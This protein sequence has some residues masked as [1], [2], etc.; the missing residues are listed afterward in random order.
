MAWLTAIERR[1]PYRRSPMD[2]EELIARAEDLKSE[3]EKL[4]REFRADEPDW[5][6][7]ERILPLDWCG[8]F[9]FMGYSGEI[10][11]YK[12]GLTRRYLNVDPEGNTCAY[13]GETIGY[14]KIPRERAIEAAFAGLEE[15]GYTRGGDHQ[16]MR[17]DRRRRL[18]EA[19]WTIVNLG[20]GDD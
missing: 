20:P 14:R 5:E 6:P 16:A 13:F 10:R 15:M 11:L 7:L 8:S 2:R 19:G 18:E 12:H 9:M 4:L 3:W 1:D 17:A